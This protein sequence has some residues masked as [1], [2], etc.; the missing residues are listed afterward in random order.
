MIRVLT[1]SMLYPN[2]CQPRHGIFVEQRLRQLVA[3]G[4]VRARVVAPVPW[5][6]FTG[7]AFGRYGMYGAIPRR[8][9][10]HGI[11]IAHPRF[12]A[13]PKVG[14][15]LAPRL[16]AG[17]MRGALHRLIVGQGDF[18]VIDAHYLY[19]DGV[20]ATL[21]GRALDKP[22]I[23]TCR[24]DDVMSFSRFKLPRQMMVSA[25]ERA[26]AL[27]TVSVD[28]KQR[29]LDLGV[30]A[31]RVRVL[32]NG[33]DLELFKP[34]DRD[35]ARAALGFHRPTLLSVGHLIERKG[36]HLAIE[37]LAKLPGYDLVVIGERGTEGGGMVSELQAQ[38][39]KLGL[40]RR[41]RFVANVSQARLGEYYGAADALVLAT[42]REGMPN[43]MLEALAC[44]TPV[45]ATPV[46]G[47][48][49]VMTVP[50]AGVLM[51]ERTSTGVVEAVKAL[52]NAYPDRNETR[53]FAQRFGWDATT[54]GQLKLFRQVLDGEHPGALQSGCPTRE[55]G[56]A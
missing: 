11:E 27:I 29:L 56:S 7:K 19:P 33:V 39:E 36:H 12:P 54:E 5:F 4:E 17:A 42:D 8:E 46:G 31:S 38:V 2:Q 50:E 18:D 52:F 34:V 45:I 53:R 47:I 13:I 40:G 23:I 6:P 51:K 26:D 14:M 20:A 3:T 28:L 1:F 37:A 35:A 9:T 41:V 32:A 44:G 22:V 25:A 48:P 49:E 43:V 10:R 24:G 21:L 15:T 30:P 55:A 16:L